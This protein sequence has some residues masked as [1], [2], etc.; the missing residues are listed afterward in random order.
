M[1]V[2]RRKS[3]PVSLAG[4]ARV[5]R[6]HADATPERLARARVG[7]ET[8]V[9][10]AGVRRIGDPFDA[11]RSRNLLDRLDIAANETLWHAGER[12]RRHWWMSRL[13]HLSAVDFA[14]P[15]VDGGGADVGAPGEAAQRHRDELRRAAAAVGPRL[16]PY[17]EGVVIAGRPVASLR[18]LV[19]DTGHARTADALA[20]E[21][22]REGLYRL[23]DLWRMR[24]DARPLPIASWRAAGDAAVS[25]GEPEG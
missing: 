20:L 7:G 5:P 21:R 23:C 12:L 22:L 15:S 1:T 16:M 4:E 25:D 19:G 24:P 17:V 10:R 11:L 14:R 6:G 9:D 13:D 2:P 8:G 3:A 18:G